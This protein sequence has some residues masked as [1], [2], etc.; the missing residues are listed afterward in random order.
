[1]GSMGQFLAVALLMVGGQGA[2]QA[3]GWS[4]CWRSTVQQVRADE[5]AVPG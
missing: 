5:R 2:A 3:Q 4:I 1:M